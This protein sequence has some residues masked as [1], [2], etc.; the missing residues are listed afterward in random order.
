MINRYICRYR[1][2]LG[3]LLVYDVRCCGECRISKD[4]FVPSICLTTKCFERCFHTKGPHAESHME[5][6]TLGITW[7]LTWPPP[8]STSKDAK[9]QGSC[10]CV[11]WSDAGP[12]RGGARGRRWRR[13]VH[14]SR[15]LMR[16]MY[17]SMLLYHYSLRKIVQCGLRELCRG[18]KLFE[19]ILFLALFLLKEKVW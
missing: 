10:C 6:H 16:S 14:T 19:A 13:F 5:L 4:Q 12:R 9:A 17:S 3:N 18:K 2:K 15:P 8:A 7:L 11:F 1:V